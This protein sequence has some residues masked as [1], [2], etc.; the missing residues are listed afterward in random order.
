MELTWTY[1][2]SYDSYEIEGYSD[3]VSEM[4]MIVY[5][6]WKC[7]EYGFTITNTEYIGMTHDGYTLEALYDSED[8][9]P[10]WLGDFKL[11]KNAQEHAQNL[12][13]MEED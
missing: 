13:D 2:E 3:C 6:E 7:N 8:S 11:L 1:E 9:E 10:V 5:H 12:V 4:G